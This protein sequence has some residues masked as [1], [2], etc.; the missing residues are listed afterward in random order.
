MS[1]RGSIWHFKRL[2]KS[3][4]IL[5]K[6]FLFAWALGSVWFSR[7]GERPQ[8]RNRKLSQNDECSKWVFD[9]CGHS[10]HPNIKHLPTILI[11]I[12][13]KLFTV[14]KTCLLLVFKEIFVKMLISNEICSYIVWKRFEVYRTR[15][16]DLKIMVKV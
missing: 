9:P 4:L 12:F 8:F 1:Y 11:Q 7:Y 10:A 5:K 14:S 3:M 2:R 15:T 13:K 6:S 16:R